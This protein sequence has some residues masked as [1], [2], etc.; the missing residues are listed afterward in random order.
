MN[1]NFKRFIFEEIYLPCAE[2]ADVE[3]FNVLIDIK[4]KN[5]IDNW[6]PAKTVQTGW[7][8]LREQF[9][10]TL[11]PNVDQRKSCDQTQNNESDDQLFQRLKMAVSETVLE[12]HQWD[13][14]AADVIV[15]SRYFSVRSHYRFSFFF[16]KKLLQMNSSEDRI[17]SSKEK[18]KESAKY[19]QDLINDRIVSSKFIY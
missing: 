9:Q 15:S 3:N 14:K 4:L 19:W 7:Q 2:K 10:K 8:V 17:V 1:E 11:I 5:W 12:H 6:L 13:G 16:S 18:W